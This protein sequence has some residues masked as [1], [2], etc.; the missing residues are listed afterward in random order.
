MILCKF[1]DTGSKMTEGKKAEECLNFPRS[2]QFLEVRLIS[3]NRFIRTVRFKR[4]DT[5][6]P[7]H[8]GV[9][10][11]LKCFICGCIFNVY[12]ILITLFVQ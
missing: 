6:I 12:Y 2:N 4:H 10:I 11:Y 8:G 5:V 1:P 3:A 7:W 9:E